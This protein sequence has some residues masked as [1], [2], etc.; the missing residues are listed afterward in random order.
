MGCGNNSKIT[1]DVEHVAITRN[2]S[3]KLPKSA[4]KKK[5]ET[6][7]KKKEKPAPQNEDLERSESQKAKLRNRK[8]T[9]AANVVSNK[10][11]TKMQELLKR[12]NARLSGVEYLED[13]YNKTVAG[14]VKG[15]PSIR[16]VNSN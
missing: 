15:R 2:P 4:P 6:P 16:C 8:P 14:L 13:L 3:T 7:K 1:T 11:K 10:H 12:E 5:K 9:G